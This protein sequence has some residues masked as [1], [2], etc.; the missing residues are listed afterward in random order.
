FKQKT[1]YEITTGDWSSDVCSSDLLPADGDRRIGRQRCAPGRD[2]PLRAPAHHGRSDADPVRQEGG[3]PP[4][5]NQPGLPLSQ[6]SHRGETALITSS[7]TRA[8]GKSMLLVI[9]LQ[10]VD[11]QRPPAISW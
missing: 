4:A 10:V 5:G 3:G 6:A 11:F 1:A 2:P 7:E 9:Q 8:I